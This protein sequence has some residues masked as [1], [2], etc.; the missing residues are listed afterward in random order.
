MNP[1]IEVEKEVLS[2]HRIL[3]CAH[4]GTYTKHVLSKSGEYYSCR[5]GSIVDIDVIEKEKEDV[6]KV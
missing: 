5:C 1:V 2:K 6:C 4:C 3:F